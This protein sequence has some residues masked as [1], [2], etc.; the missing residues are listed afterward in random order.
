MV[1]WM[2]L[3]LEFRNLDLVIVLC[4]LFF[5]LVFVFV[6]R[7]SSFLGVYCILEKEILRVY[8]FDYKGGL[9]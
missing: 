6:L 7:K 2:K 4:L 5:Y 8:G 3:R 9:V 1:C